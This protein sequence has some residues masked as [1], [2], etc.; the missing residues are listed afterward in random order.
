MVD[1]KEPVLPLGSF[2]FPQIFRS[3]RMAIQPS[4]LL[5]AFAALA[6]ICVAGWVMDLNPTVA[7][8]DAPAVRPGSDFGVQPAPA[9]TGLIT[10]LDVYV[11]PGDSDANVIA[12]RQTANAR[13]GVFATL[14]DFGTR[15]FHTALYAIF[16]LDIS[17]V[18]PSVVQSVVHCIEALIWAFTYHVIY[19]IIFFAIVVVV[20]ALAGGAICRIAAMQFARGEKPRLVEAVRFGVR[21]FTAI[22]A[23]PV[24][25]VA[26]IVVIGLFIVGLGLA[27]NIPFVGELLAGLFLSLALIAGFFISVVLIG[28]V[29]GLNLMAPAIAYEDSDCFD[30]VSRSFSYVYAKP[31]RMGFYT[32]VAVLY[33]AIC[34]IFVR[35]FAFLLLWSVYRFL[36][37]GFLGDN[38]K[39]HAIWPEPTFA[40]F[41]GA[42]AAA[43]ETGSLWLGALLIRLW[44]LAVVGLMVSFLISFYFSA[45]TVIYAL[46]RNRVDHTP[47]DEVYL[48]SDEAALE[49][50]R[51]ETV[52]EPLPA[53]PEQ[54]A[55]GEPQESPKTSE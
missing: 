48:Y 42:A 55:A 7:V 10:E 38:L 13:T 39:L 47:L 26:V 2:L 8:M 34:Y 51:L 5:L 30:A 49:P 53:E 19:S 6:V 24:T 1:E 32:V 50:A 4:K 9:D 43:P 16:A 27:G 15:Q 52:S 40:E 28:T 20:M 33:G 21:K 23:A 18:V 17:I 41:A 22:L 36:E 31:W 37:V 54:E 44:V 14:W 46:I 3:F 25:P 45:H 12:L 11:S 29:A 35:F